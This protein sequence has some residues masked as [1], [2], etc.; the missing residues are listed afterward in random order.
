MHVN[1]EQIF[2]GG[3]LPR[4]CEHVNKPTSLF[5]RDQYVIFS[6][7]YQCTAEIST[8]NVLLDPNTNVHN[9][10]S[11]TISLVNFL[12]LQTLDDTDSNPDAIASVDWMIVNWKER[13]RKQP[14]TNLRYHSG[15]QA[16]RD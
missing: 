6:C 16:E 10:P 5:T 3:Q 14:W 15:I 9:V 8:V 11:R 7:F 1:V 2:L 4:H 13:G 12:H